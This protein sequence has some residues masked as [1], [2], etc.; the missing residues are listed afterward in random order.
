VVVSAKLYMPLPRTIDET[1]RVTQVPDCSAPEDAVT[2]PEGAG[3][4][5]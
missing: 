3:A 2:V 4:F 5:A 1:S